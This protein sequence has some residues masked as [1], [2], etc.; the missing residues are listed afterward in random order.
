MSGNT[1]Q[2][3]ED[4]VICTAID[5]DWGDDRPNLLMHP[6]CECPRCAPEAVDQKEEGSWLQLP[7]RRQRLR[8]EP[9]HLGETGRST[10]G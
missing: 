5:N 3:T 7:G 10:L 8:V 1:R 6:P 2:V 9:A 4:E